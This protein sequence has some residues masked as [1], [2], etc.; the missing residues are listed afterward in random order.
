MISKEQCRAARGFLNWS[1][2]VLAARAGIDR[3]TVKDF[4]SGRHIP[5]RVSMTAIIGAFEMAGIEFTNGDR[6]GLRM[7]RPS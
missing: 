6:P 2:A 1:Q 7:R 4:E 3:S 5:N